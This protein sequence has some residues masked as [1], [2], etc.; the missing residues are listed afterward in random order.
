MSEN[1]PDLNFE[2]DPRLVADG[3]ERRF[4]ADSQRANEAVELY[5]SLGYEVRAE[6][7]LPS[8][9]SDLCTDCKLV[10][11]S[12]YVTIYTRKKVDE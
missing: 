11:C 4:M 8:E 12:T 3:W 1:L 5:T 10:V 2:A 6:S 9:L 7:V